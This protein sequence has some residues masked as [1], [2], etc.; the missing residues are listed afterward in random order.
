MTTADLKAVL[1]SAINGI[2]L[3]R[4]LV[5]PVIVEKIT[6]AVQQ[7]LCPTNAPILMLISNFIQMD[8]GD[9]SKLLNGIQQG[10]FFEKDLLENNHDKKYLEVLTKLKDRP[11]IL[12]MICSLVIRDEPQLTGEQTCIDVTF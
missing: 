11:L 12:Q 1:D 10:I 5:S 2:N 4:Q 3:N 9:V 6:N 8:I 7:L